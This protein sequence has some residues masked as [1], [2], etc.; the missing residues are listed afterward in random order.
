MGKTIAFLSQKGGVG[1]STLA[2]AVA[3]EA[4]KSGLSVRL[5]DLDVQ[6]ATSADW[7]RQR[8]A[9]G[10]EPVGSVEVFAKAADALR[11][12]ADVDLLVLDGAP[13]ASSGTLEAAFAADLAVLPCCPSRDDLVPSLKLAC[14]LEQHG[15]SR[16]KIVFALVRAATKAETAD[17]REYIEQAGFAVLDGSLPEKP[18][19]RQ[20]QNEGR[21]VTE[22]RWSSLNK[23]ADRLL[24]SILKHLTEEAHG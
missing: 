20:A 13:R 21:A 1:K 18:A 9:C 19:Y 22:T 5:A 23:Q 12:A 14:E 7:H 4:S 8:L 6:Q 16:R 3:C 17:A 2:R 15:V 24:D 11:T 10:H